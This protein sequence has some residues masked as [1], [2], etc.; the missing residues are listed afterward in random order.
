[1]S[2]PTAERSPAQ[3]SEAVSG[4]TAD[5]SSEPVRAALV[6]SVPIALE[7]YAFQRLGQHGSAICYRMLISLV[8]LAIVL[9]AIFGLFLR[10]A[11]LQA[12]VVDWIV[13][14]LPF[15]E[16]SR[17]DVENAIV[18]IAS[19]ASLLGFFALIAFGWTATGLLG[20]IR[21]GLE[22]ALDVTVRRPAVRSK[23][24]D[25]AGVVGAALLVIVLAVTG[26]VGDGVRAAIEDV[27]GWLHV[28]LPDLGLS[29]GSRAV[30]GLAVFVVVL[31][32]YRFV[33][34]RR[35]PTRHLLVGALTASVMLVVISLG[36]S[37]LY[38]SASDLSVIYG[39]LTVLFT[40]LYAVYLSACALLLGAAY[41]GA[42]SEPPR[43]PGPP[44]PTQVRL[45]IVGLFRRPREPEA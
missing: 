5:A 43:P 7:A 26:A 22:A 14:F 31:A 8:P 38:G 4:S 18:A 44:L 1:M 36:S 12:R 21:V 24:V 25:A 16:S 11:E 45:A 13:D 10:D 9:V 19:P 37:L 28:P 41:A 42:L 20:A 3:P 15:D 39:S 30:E 35:L 32:L 6:R 23:L 34:A 17:Q 29:I 2:E 40:F 27:A 33:P